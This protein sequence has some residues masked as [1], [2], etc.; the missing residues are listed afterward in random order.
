MEW[1]KTCMNIMAGYRTKYIIDV[2]GYDGGGVVDVNAFSYT[3]LH[4]QY[5]CS[6]LKHIM[7]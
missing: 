5:M 7:E 6:T 2:P 4:H 1:N 3:A